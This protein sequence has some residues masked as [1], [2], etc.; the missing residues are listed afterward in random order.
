MVIYS[1]EHCQILLVRLVR[2]VLGLDG[3]GGRGRLV[4]ALGHHRH[5]R[6]RVLGG[7]RDGQ[8]GALRLVTVHAGRVGDG[9]GVAV[10]V[11]VAV[12]SLDSIAGLAAVASHG[13]A[14][15][16]GRDAVL[17][18]E[19]VGKISLFVKHFICSIFKLIPMSVYV[20]LLAYHTLH[21]FK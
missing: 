9:V 2:L 8:V 20:D 14:R 11:G 19:A 15:L 13:L 16:G 18:F 3:L 21:D 12:L 17:R 1:R 6:G 4:I 10:V 7:H 5:L